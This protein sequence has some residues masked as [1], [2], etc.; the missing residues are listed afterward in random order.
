MSS[1]PFATIILWL[2]N[3]KNNNNSF[4]EKTL[5]CNLH[6]FFFFEKL[7]AYLECAWKVMKVEVY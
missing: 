3:L 5:F 1:M 4:F 7:V 2:L 6:F